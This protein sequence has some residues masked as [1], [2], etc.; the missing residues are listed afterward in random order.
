MA[1]VPLG[2]T[3]RPPVLAAAPGEPGQPDGPVPRCLTEQHKRIFSATA[4]VLPYPTLP[5]LALRVSR[6]Y[7]SSSTHPSVPALVFFGLPNAPRLHQMVT[8]GGP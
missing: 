8:L 3:A 7:I 1:D 4:Q 5:G 6:P 2:R